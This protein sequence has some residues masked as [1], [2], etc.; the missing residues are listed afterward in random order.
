MSPRQTQKQKLNETSNKLAQIDQESTVLHFLE[1]IQC[2]FSDYFDSNIH[3]L[4]NFDSLKSGLISKDNLKF[5]ECKEKEDFKKRCTK[6]SKMLKATEEAEQALLKRQ[7]F[8]SNDDLTKDLE[9]MH[10]S[11]LSM[12]EELKLIKNVFGNKETSNESFL[13]SNNSDF[14]TNQALTE[15]PK[16]AASNSNAIR[17]RRASALAIQVDKLCNKKQQRTSAIVAASNFNNQKT[18]TQLQKQRSK[19]SNLSGHDLDKI[20]DSSKKTVCVQIFSNT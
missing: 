11:L 4:I 1:E 20:Y 16:E 5:Y 15:S 18:P 19:I 7:L 13:D 10:K 14:D 2:N 9:K 12:D 8:N 3:K 6:N 17:S